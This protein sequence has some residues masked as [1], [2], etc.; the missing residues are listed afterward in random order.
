MGVSLP[1][2]GLSWK[3][4]LQGMMRDLSVQVEAEEKWLFCFDELPLAIDNIREDN[5]A[6]AAMGVLDT[7]RSIRQEYPQIR[8]VYS[9]SILFQR[10]SANGLHHVVAD[11]KT[12]GY[13]NAPTNDMPLVEVAPFAAFDAWDLARKSIVGEGIATDSLEDVSQAIAATVNGIPFYIHH[14]VATLKEL[15]TLVQWSGN[16]DTILRA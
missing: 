1:K 2:P 3:Q 16:N 14:S 7:L 12:Q 9:G 11:L 4:H 8:M 10:G 15:N 5:G 13:R 6:N